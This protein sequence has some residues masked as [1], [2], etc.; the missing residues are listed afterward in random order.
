MLFGSGNAVPN[1]PALRETVT[2]GVLTGGCML[3]V[4]ATPWP[5][6]LLWLAMFVWQ[7]RTLAGLVQAHRFWRAH[8]TLAALS[9]E[10]RRV[11]ASLE[12]FPTVHINS[13]QR[14]VFFAEDAQLR[15]LRTA[16]VLT[17][18]SADDSDEASHGSGDT[19]ITGHTVY[20]ASV[21]PDD[22]VP[23]MTMS[24]ADETRHTDDE[25]V[26]V[27]EPAT[28]RRRDTAR[29]IALLMRSGYVFASEADLTAVLVE[30]RGID[31]AESLD[32]G[33]DGTEEEQ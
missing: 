3:G 18:Q 22:R 11:A 10:F 15:W 5:M 28:I 25:E 17:R 33:W 6:S 9:V 16:T 31:H 32:T 8:P 12:R 7:A 24:G 14:L 23:V 26:E 1:Q 4:L 13:G 30:L 27:V 20:V 29:S 2:T 19:R 21:R